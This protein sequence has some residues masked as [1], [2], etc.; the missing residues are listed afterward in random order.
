MNTI[1][2]LDNI[3]YHIQLELFQDNIEFSMVE[4]KN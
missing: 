2:N 3:D 1:K 4:M